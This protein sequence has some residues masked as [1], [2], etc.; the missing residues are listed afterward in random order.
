MSYIVTRPTKSR[1]IAALLVFL[2]WPLGMFYSTIAGALIMSFGVGPLLLWAIFKSS[3]LA[4]VLLPFYFISCLVWAILAVNNHNRKIIREASDYN[5][6]MSNQLI[7]SKIESKYSQQEKNELRN[8]L[9]RLKILY[10][11]NVIDRNKYETQKDIMEKKIYD[12]ENRKDYQQTYPSQEVVNEKKTSILPLLFIFLAIFL[13]AFILY[14]SKTNSFKIDRITSIFSTQQSKEK[15]EIKK[16]LEK[17]YFD[18][19]N[20]KYTAQNFT[21]GVET[22]FYN[23]NVNTLIVMGLGPLATFTGNLK[24]EP[25]NIDVYELNENDNTAKLKY[26]IKI[27][28]KEDTVL[29]KIDMD[30]KK[31]GGL[32]K[33]NADK[34][35]KNEKTN[36]KKKNLD[37]KKISINTNSDSFSKDLNTQVGRRIDLPANQQYLLFF[38]DYDEKVSFDEFLI[39]GDILYCNRDLYNDLG[40]IIEERRVEKMYRIKLN[41]NSYQIIDKENLPREFSLYSVE[42]ESKKADVILD[43]IYVND[44]NEKVCIW[45]I[46]WLKNSKKE[47]YK[48]I[49]VHSEK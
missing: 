25:N 9:R 30:A 15:E 20:G 36:G 31:I 29:G 44:K 34:F 22:P 8:D 3:G 33:F 6:K 13:I 11:T 27:I 21:G 5:N 40:D 12:L 35:F 38:I 46:E 47:T 7:D 28:T 24:V 1:G 42:D 32:W 14:D 16:Q 49:L 19:L 4:L 17:T 45:N 39:I 2:F 23:T 37:K 10:D 48:T 26:D 41:D 43:D 18:V